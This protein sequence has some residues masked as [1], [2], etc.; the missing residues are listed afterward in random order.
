MRGFPFGWF[1]RFYFSAT[2]P[3]DFTSHSET[4][5][6]V[7]VEPVINKDEPFASKIFAAFFCRG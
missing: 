4:H 1:D 3:D 6:P 2:S 7:R 5:G